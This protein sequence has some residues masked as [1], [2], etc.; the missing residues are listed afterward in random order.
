MFSSYTPNSRMLSKFNLV[1]RVLY[2][3]SLVRQGGAGENPGNEVWPNLIF[4]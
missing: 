2:Y 1:S 4:F 3:L